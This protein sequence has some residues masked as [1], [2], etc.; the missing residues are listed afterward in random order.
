MASFCVKTSKLLS[1]EQQKSTEKLIHFFPGIELKMGQAVQFLLAI[2]KS[3]Y[4]LKALILPITSLMSQKAIFL[5]W[6]AVKVKRIFLI[7][8]D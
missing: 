3:H 7:G 2:S 1:M 5:T 4:H 6:K 8:V